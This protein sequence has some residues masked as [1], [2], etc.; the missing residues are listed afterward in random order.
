MKHKFGV[1]NKFGKGNPA[2]NAIA[3][4][5]AAL[6][7]AVKMK[8]I[9]AVLNMLVD[10][11]VRLKDVGAAKLFLEYSCGKPMV[12]DGGGAISIAE[13]EDRQIII[14]VNNGNNTNNDSK[15]ETQPVST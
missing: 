4:H 9:K 8:D 5:R 2:Y 7:K 13:G 12:I 6:L 3:E 10:K 11:A 14:S 15:P 1:G